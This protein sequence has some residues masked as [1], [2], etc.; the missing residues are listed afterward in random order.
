MIKDELNEIYDNTIP[1]SAFLNKSSI[2]SCMMQSYLL[3]VQE[4]DEKYQK[5]KKAF[6]DLLGLWGDY[7]KYN[8]GRS[9]MEEDWR[10]EGGLL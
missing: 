6:E 7:G 10:K 2:D 5:L 8:D 4:S 9:H 3:G 1:H